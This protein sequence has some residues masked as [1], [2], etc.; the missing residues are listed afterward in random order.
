MLGSAFGRVLDNRDFDVIAT[1]REPSRVVAPAFEFRQF[2]VD[3]ADAATVIEHLPWTPDYVVNC[4]GL[5]K[6]HIR[7]EDPESRRAAIRIN[8]EFPYTLDRLAEAFG[9]TVIQIATD[10][11]YAGDI[12]GYAESAPHDPVDVYGKTKSLGEVPSP[13]FLN[14]RCS[15]I[16]RELS[17]KQ[18]LLEWVLGHGPGESFNGYL[19]HHWNGVTT[20]AFARVAAGIMENRTTWSGVQH[21]VPADAVNKAELSGMILKTFGRSDVEVNPIVT[22][23]LVDRTLATDNPIVNVHLWEAGGYKEPPT[24]RQMVT[25]LA[26]TRA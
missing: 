16:G 10:C 11:V 14:L 9:F 7:D 6:H 20:E 23:T 19:D 24:V 3:S 25:E 1:T 8:A 21:L 26:H 4:I 12:G 13:R 15:I 5:I 18:S 17:G 22:G 2:D